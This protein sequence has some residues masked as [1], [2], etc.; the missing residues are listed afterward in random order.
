MAQ[1]LFWYA[2]AIV[3]WETANIRRQHPILSPE[4]LEKLMLPKE[5]CCFG[6]TQE[7]RRHDSA[8]EPA[9]VL[10]SGVGLNGKD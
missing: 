2:P 4:Q 7:R 8:H 10:H 5:A 6:R 1:T 3:V 9:A